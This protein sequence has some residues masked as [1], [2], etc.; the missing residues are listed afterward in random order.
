MDAQVEGDLEEFVDLY[1]NS[2][3][4]GSRE[5]KSEPVLGRQYSETSQI[6]ARYLVTLKRP[7]GLLS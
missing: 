5:S 2:V 1:L 6:L 7:K 3:E 4:V